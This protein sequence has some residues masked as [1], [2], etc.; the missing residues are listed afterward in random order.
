MKYYNAESYEVNRFNDAI[1][2][3]QV[4][5]AQHQW[6]SWGGGRSRAS[7]APVGKMEFTVG[8]VWRRQHPRG[9]CL[10]QV[11]EW[12]VSA[13]L[14]LLN[15]TQNLVIGLGLLAGSLL[16]AYFVTENK[17][18]VRLVPAWAAPGL[19]WGPGAGNDRHLSPV[20]SRWGTLSSSAP[21]S[22]SSTRRSTGSGLTTGNAGSC[23]GAWGPLP[24][25][26][27]GQDVVPQTLPP[28]LRPLPG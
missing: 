25:G 24:P 17:L 6:G 23:G 10:F 11:S 28:G 2:K 18:Q 21:T 7:R 8:L 4:R 27:L 22:S 15:Q 1:I 13:S 5:G 14:G 12:K 20:P 16:C 19:G 26:R 9:P 3:Y